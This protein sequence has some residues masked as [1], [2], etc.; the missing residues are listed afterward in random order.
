MRNNNLEYRSMLMDGIKADAG[1]KTITGRAIAFNKLSNELRTMSGD[2]FFEMILPGAVE[3]SMSQNDILAYREHNPEMLLGRKSAGTLKLEK[4]ADGLYATIDIPDTSY[5]RD[6]L[7]SARRG[8]LAGFSFGFNKPVARTYTN[9]E[10]MKIR[11]ISAMDLREVSV[12][13]SPAYNDTTLSVRSEDF[14]PETDMKKE[15]DPSKEVI[16]NKREN[17]KPEIKNNDAVEK[18]YALKHRF[19]ALKTL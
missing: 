17:P 1:G 6:T 7:E 18:H 5:G 15:F 12:V 14:V 10:G 9:K 19:N 3:Q 4:R 11:E 13:S 8:D 2:K 16:V